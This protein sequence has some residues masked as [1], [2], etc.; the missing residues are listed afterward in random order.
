MAFEN[1]PTIHGYASYRSTGQTGTPVPL[2]THLI[3]PPNCACAVSRVINYNGRSVLLT[4]T[5]QQ[6]DEMGCQNQLL[7]SLTMLPLFSPLPPSDTVRT[8][9]KYL[10]DLFG[11][12]LS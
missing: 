12:V 2:T 1:R 3:F 6:P 11:S 7:P 8:Q 5:C 4:I 10:E 9:K